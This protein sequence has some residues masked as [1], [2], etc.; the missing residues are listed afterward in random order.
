MLLQQVAAGQDRCLM[1]APALLSGYGVGG[2]DSLDQCLPEN[3]RLHLHLELL[4]FSLLLGDGL[5]VIREA[6]L[7]AAH[8]PCPHRATA[9]QMGW[10]VQ[11][12]P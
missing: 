2:L 7:L 12:F 1:R 11:G 8:P 3:H 10:M 9:P 5:L 4:A 6:E